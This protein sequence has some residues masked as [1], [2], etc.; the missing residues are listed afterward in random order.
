MYSP[1]PLDG[2]SPPPMSDFSP[3][4]LSDLSPLRDFPPPINGFS[5]GDETEDDGDFNFALGDN[6]YDLTGLSDKINRLELE[7]MK[8]LPPREIL[9]LKRESSSLFT[10]NIPLEPAS[11]LQSDIDIETNGEHLV[12]QAKNSC[13]LTSHDLETESLEEHNVNIGDQETICD[14]GQDDD[15]ND[16]ESS[17]IETPREEILQSAAM[18][19]AHNEGC[20]TVENEEDVPVVEDAEDEE[21][22]IQQDNE[23][24]NSKT[25]A[26]WESGAFENVAEDDDACW[27]E[28][29]EDDPANGSESWSNFPPVPTDEWSLPAETNMDDKADLQFDDSEDDD[30]GDFGEASEQV[31][32]IN[33]EEIESSLFLELKELIEKSNSMLESV[34]N[35][36]H[37]EVEAGD[38]VVRTCLQEAVMREGEIFQ[39]IEIPAAAPALEHE[40]R[41]SATYN[42]L[43]LTLGIDSS[44]NV[45]PD[46]DR[47]PRVN[48]VVLQLEGEEWR[49]SAGR[50]APRSAA[51]LMTPGL[52]TPQAVTER[53]DQPE[54]KVNHL[55]HPTSCPHISH[56]A[57]L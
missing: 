22:V 51:S 53:P 35:L 9:E 45:G 20:K 41:N 21:E 39:K 23:V 25:E 36:P 49:S 38:E 12:K 13:P 15:K 30:F 57:G 24:V 48:V 42:T 10:D 54:Q 16:S 8:S 4:P 18:E 7:K 47:Q 2:F 40:W 26:E 56:I 55:L 32:N 14:R 43:L 46:D 34:Y 50:L 1:P 3:P 17:V 6:Q 29:P 11:D 52:L 37:G 5:G 31:Q 33:K 19:S 27:G 28:F 44:S